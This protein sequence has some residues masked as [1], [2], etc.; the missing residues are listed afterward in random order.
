[1][2]PLRRRLRSTVVQGRVTV[3]TIPSNPAVLARRAEA[4][5]ASIFAC[6]TSTSL[7]GLL[8]RT[9]SPYEQTDSNADEFFIALGKF[10]SEVEGDSPCGLGLTTS[11]GQPKLGVD[12]GPIHLVRAGLINQVEELGWRVFFDGHHQFEGVSP[13]P[14]G[15]Q[16]NATGDAAIDTLNTSIAKLRSPLFV[17]QVCESVASAVQAHAAM[18]H[19]PVTLGGD[20]SLAM[21]TISGTLRAYD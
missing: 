2:L 8:A 10:T 20:H 17:A 13:P 5:K 9:M 12:K 21:G 19:L 14:N 4:S 18:G 11:G 1:M 7:T 15:I 3:I 16:V 6:S